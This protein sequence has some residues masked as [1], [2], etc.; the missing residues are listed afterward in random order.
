MD[1]HA[2]KSRVVWITNNLAVGKVV[3]K[4]TETPPWYRSAAEFDRDTK[5]WPEIMVIKGKYALE[6]F[7]IVRSINPLRKKNQAFLL[8]YVEDYYE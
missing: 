8:K 7:V 3:S 5:G 4:K 2:T 1:R 6:G